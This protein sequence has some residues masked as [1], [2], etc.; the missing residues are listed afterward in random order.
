MIPYY[1]GRD[2][3]YEPKPLAFFQRMYNRVAFFMQKYKLN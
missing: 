3:I 2:V 1:V